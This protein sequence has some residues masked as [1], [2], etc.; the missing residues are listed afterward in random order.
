MIYVMII[1]EYH[2]MI[3]ENT[4]ETALLKNDVFGGAMNA[5]AGVTMDL[6][7]GPIV[8][9]TVDAPP[10]PAN[11]TVNL[12]IINERMANMSI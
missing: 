4:L 10:V 5:R 3:L 8:R 9:E 12:S 11:P 2:P 6:A 7:D 1:D